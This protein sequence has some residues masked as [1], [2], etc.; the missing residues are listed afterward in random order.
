MDGD[1]RRSSQYGQPY[2]TP[3]SVRGAPGQSM[4]P[5]TTERFTTPST[6]ART[7]ID[8]SSLTQSYLPG[9][10]G[11][12]YQAQPYTPTQMHSSSPMQGVEMQYSQSYIHDPTRQQQVQQTN[13]Q[14]QQ[15]PQYAQGSL[16][17]HGQSQQMYDPLHG[18]QQR[19]SS[20]I[21]TLSG[22]FTV[23]AYMQQ[24]EQ[25]PVAVL[26]G[27]RQYLSSQSEQS[28]YASIPPSRSSISHTY[29]SA[30]YTM[31]EPPGQQE[32]QTGSTS[33]AVLD[34]DMKSFEQQL[35]STFE[36]VIAG[37]LTDASERILQLTKWLVN[38]VPAL[39]K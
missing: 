33:Q 9:S 8:R 35:R 24:T 25:S 38:S 16:L 36:T 19:Q 37:R 26:P 7:D 6:P 27:S 1:D 5:P 18:Y 22:N 34:E 32:S 11:Y 28:S 13:P 21:D 4:G 20:S 29:S 39:G 3:G 17:S 31:V 15:Y 2:P 12:T 14:H 23:P 30:E 10:Y